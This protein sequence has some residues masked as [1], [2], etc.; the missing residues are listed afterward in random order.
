MIKE[1]FFQGGSEIAK[2]RVDYQ[3]NTIEVATRM[4]GYSYR[5]LNQ[6]VSAKKAMLFYGYINTMTMEEFE[7]Y[8]EKEFKGMGYKLKAKR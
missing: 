2:V 8:L 3:D 1:Y 4:T 5:K 6:L 7:Q